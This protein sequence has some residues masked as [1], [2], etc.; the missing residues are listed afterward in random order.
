MGNDGT[1]LFHIEVIDED[2]DHWVDWTWATSESDAVKNSEYG[3]KIILEVRPATED[4]TSAWEEGFSEAVGV[5]LTEER[6][7][8]W[9]GVVYSVESFSPLRT[10]E[11]FTCGVCEQNLVMEQASK[12]GNFYLSIRTPKE[13]Q[14]NKTVLWHVCRKCAQA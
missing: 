14:L 1:S 11:M 7:A 10:K 2:G 9:N 6:M 8:N 4:E 12:L 13:E 3:G 5:G